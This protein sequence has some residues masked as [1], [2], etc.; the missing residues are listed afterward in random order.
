[1]IDPQNDAQMLAYWAAMP[2]LPQKDANSAGTAFEGDC[3]RCLSRNIAREVFSARTAAG[4]RFHFSKDIAEEKVRGKRPLAIPPALLN[5]L[6]FR[7]GFIEPHIAHVAGI[8]T[9]GIIVFGAAVTGGQQSLVAFLIDGTHRG[10]AA[11]RAAS[12]FKAYYL[13]AR[14]TAHCMMETQ[15]WMATKKAGVFADVEQ[16]RE[17]SSDRRRGSSDSPR[18]QLFLN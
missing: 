2:N 7:N 5:F 12:E 15:A 13:G 11:L 16:R 1:M 9:P 10:I 14:D 18:Q 6:A 17:T 3:P 8:D 4:E